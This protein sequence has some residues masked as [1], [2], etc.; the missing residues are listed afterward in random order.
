MPSNV[1]LAKRRRAFNEGRIA[2]RQGLTDNPYDNA[3]LRGLWERGRT[4]ERKGTIKSPIERRGKAQGEPTRPWPARRM[5][6]G[7]RNE[8]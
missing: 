2:A 7:I 4:G 1:T 6:R 5:E 8:S 3:T